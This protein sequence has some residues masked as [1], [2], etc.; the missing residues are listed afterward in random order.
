M[1]AENERLQ[2][3]LKVATQKLP[4]PAEGDGIP[5]AISGTANPDRPYR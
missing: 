3:D 1:K 4:S 5:D 2:Q